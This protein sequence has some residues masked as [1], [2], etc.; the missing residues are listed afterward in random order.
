MPDREIVRCLF[1]AWRY[2]TK[3]DDDLASRLFFADYFGGYSQIELDMHYTEHYSMTDLILKA[4][5]KPHKDYDM[6]QRKLMITS[7]KFHVQKSSGHD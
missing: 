5:A 2:A 3:I 4:N 7:F 1:D 6:L